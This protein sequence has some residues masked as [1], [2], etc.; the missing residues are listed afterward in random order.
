MNLCCV[1]SL[2]QVPPGQAPPPG[3]Y[4]GPGMAPGQAPPPG[5]AG[6]VPGVSSGNS[7]DCHLD[8][9]SGCIHIDK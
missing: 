6:G 3:Y 8:K 5:Y 7:T 1:C 2:L 9:R 4:G